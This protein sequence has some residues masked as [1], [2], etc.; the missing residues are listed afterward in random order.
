VADVEKIRR[1][2]KKRD[3]EA[4]RVIDRLAAH[5]VEAETDAEVVEQGTGVE[6]L[7][8]VA[9]LKELEKAGCGKF[10]VGRRKHKSRMRWDVDATALRSVA[11]GEADDLP[12]I[13]HDLPL[14]DASEES[15]LLIH[16]YNLRPGLTVALSL[17]VD[18]S[19]SEAERLAKFI[20]SLPFE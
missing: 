1:L 8:V 18:L 20:E 10:M 6:Y 17:P 11:T 19:R 4:K 12:A 7:K 14:T 3:Q 5:V 2:Y 9:V 13:E 16:S 15:G